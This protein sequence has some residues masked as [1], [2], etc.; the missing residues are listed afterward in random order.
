MI[1]KE[2]F[3]LS[4]FAKEVRK[5]VDELDRQYFKKHPEKRLKEDEEKKS[6]E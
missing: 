6:G 1:K 2:L 4:L 5:E 3:N